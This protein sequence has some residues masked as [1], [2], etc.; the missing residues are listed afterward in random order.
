MNDNYTEALR[1]VGTL[2][3]DKIAIIETLTISHPNVGGINLVNDRE[4]F[5]GY[6]DLAG[7]TKIYCE[8]SSF[9]LKLPESSKDGTQF[10][11][12]AFS[13]VKGAGTEFLNKVPVESPTPIEITHRIYLPV[14]S[15]Y[16][17]STYSDGI[18][19]PQ[20]DPPLRMQAIN[21]EVSPFQINVKAAFKSLVNA[22]YPNYLYNLEDFPALSN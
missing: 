8:P 20:L 9:S 6:A 4:Q 16:P 2:N 18:P 12:I 19:L 22:K 10:M 14:N 7:G 15:E 5:V 3:H 13:N 1:E 11:S 17:Q 21:V